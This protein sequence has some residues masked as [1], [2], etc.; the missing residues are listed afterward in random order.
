MNLGHELCF[1]KQDEINFENSIHLL[2]LIK[3]NRE[4]TENVDLIDRYT[5]NCS[6]CN[7]QISS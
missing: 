5:S 1:D 6:D 2:D 4:F 3:K 7:N